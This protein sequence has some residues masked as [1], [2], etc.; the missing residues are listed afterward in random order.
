MHRKF[1]V[2]ILGSSAA[3]PT[4]LRHTSSQLVVYNN[5]HLLLDCGEGTQMQLRRL[6]LPLLKIDHIFISH[7]H[8]DHFLGLPG[9]L[10]SLH[11]LGRKRELHIYAPEGLREIIEMQFSVSGLNPVYPIE[12]HL[13]THGKQQ[14]YDD[15][16]LW[17]ETLEMDHRI[18]TFGFLL[19]EKP[20]ARNIRKEFVLGHDVPLNMIKNIKAGADFV[21]ADGKVLSNHEITT[22]G[23][24]PR[25]YAFCSDT[26]F[27]SSFL[28]QIQGVDLLYH[29]ATFMKN[30]TAIAAEKK[31]S[32]TAEAARL[33]QL[34]QAGKLLIGHYSAR[35]SDLNQL[36]EEAREVFPN[37]FLAEEGNMYQPGI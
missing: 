13:L 15:K 7:L 1:N 2:H 4:S 30:M 26:A 27:T 22:E 21:G 29:E 6:K 32:T 35:Y 11:L 33:A 5:K 16:Y 19:K 25:S 20:T 23:Y 17:V 9:L 10:F 34:A 36:L 18:P 24:K 8:G 37:T 14:I 28:D 12:Y 3:L 31:H